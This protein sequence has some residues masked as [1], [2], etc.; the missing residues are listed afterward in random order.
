MLRSGKRYNMADISEL[1]KVWMEEAKRQEER[2]EEDKRRYEEEQ[3]KAEERR[4][5]ERR[6]HEEERRRAEER[7][8]EEMRRREAAKTRRE[9]ERQ[10][11]REEDRKRYDELIKGVYE[12]KKSVE[13]GPESLKLTKLTETEDIEAFLTAY[14]RAVEA[15]NVPPEKWAVLLAPQLTGKALHAYAAMGNEEAKDYEQVK[16]AI[17]RRYDI[18]EE[19]YRR[20]LRAVSW[21]TNETSMEMLTRVTDL[22]GKWL[23]SKDTREKVVDTIVAEQFIGVLPEQARVWVKERKPTSSKEAGQLAEDFRQARK[24][25]WESASKTQKRCYTCKAV[26]HLARDCHQHKDNSMVRGTQEESQ[27]SKSIVC[28]NC[29]AKG[30]ISKNCP[31]AML[32]RVNSGRR[33]K[34]LLRCGQVDGKCVE[35]I[36]LDTGCSRTVVRKDLV[37]EEKMLDGE[38]ITIQCAHGDVVSYPLAMVEI[39]V[40]GRRIEVEAAVSAT[41]PRSVLL[42]TDVLEL[43]ELLGNKKKEGVVLL[44]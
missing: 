38:S 16:G 20:R 36:Q 4:E 3:R 39:L 21:K 35:D 44:S 1:M 30:H 13:V 26:G 10:R 24:E 17:F 15:H 19:T 43:P 34:E 5:E 37:D 12:R 31:K 14:E 18:N 9:E 2:R 23:S 25:T 8:E 22:A 7:Y 32:Y 42:G 27:K 11:E 41:L 28:F 33:G 29:K 40:G 6:R